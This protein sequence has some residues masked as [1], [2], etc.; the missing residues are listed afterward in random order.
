MVQ[1]TK[2]FC[3][4]Q[5]GA[6]YLVIRMPGVRNI[7]VQMDFVLGISELLLFKRERIWAPQIHDGWAFTRKFFLVSASKIRFQKKIKYNQVPVTFGGV[8]RKLPC[9]HL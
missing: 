3:E 6:W 9:Y 4:F 5:R 2:A 8:Q 1:D 7:S